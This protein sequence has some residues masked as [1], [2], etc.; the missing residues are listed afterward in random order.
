MIDLCSEQQG[1]N[2]LQTGPRLYNRHTSITTH[3]NIME[4]KC[5]CKCKC[6]CNDRSS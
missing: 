1:R 3:H 2:M 4:N 5:K 6:K